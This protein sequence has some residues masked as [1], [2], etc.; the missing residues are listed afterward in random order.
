MRCGSCTSSCSSALS[1][2]ASASVLSRDPLHHSELLETGRAL[3]EAAG[4]AS[5]EGA[6]S[7]GRRGAGVAS[8]TVSCPVDAASRRGPLA[9]DAADFGGDGILVVRPRRIAPLRSAE[10]FLHD[11]CES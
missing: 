3:A 10:A 1:R 7:A 8:E 2:S 9:L 6:F 11:D 5:L 4:A